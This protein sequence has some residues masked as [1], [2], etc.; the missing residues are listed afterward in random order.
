[1][2]TAISFAMEGMPPL[3]NCF[4]LFEESQIDGLQ[5]GRETNENASAPYM[6]AYI[7][8]SVTHGCMLSDKQK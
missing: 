7:R 8:L 1:M 3:M 6:M 2:L 5:S 4:L